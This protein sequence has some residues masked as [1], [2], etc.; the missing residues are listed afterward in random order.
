MENVGVM[1]SLEAGDQLGLHLVM[2]VN[3]PNPQMAV[4]GATHDFGA[5]VVPTHCVDA[6]GV[7]FQS[8]C[9]LQSIHETFQ[10]GQ[11]DRVVAPISRIPISRHCV[12]VGDGQIMQ[13][14]RPD[15]EH[16]KKQIGFKQRNI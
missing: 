8:L 2:K 6:A 16:E 11:S 15:D 5:I 9:A 12:C 13:R 10:R 4:I 3:V 7:A 14:G 1:A